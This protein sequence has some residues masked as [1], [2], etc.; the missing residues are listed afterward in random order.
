MA[1][2]FVPRVPYQ[3]N[4][5]DRKDQRIRK[6]NKRRKDT[7]AADDAFKEVFKDAVPAIDNVNEMTDSNKR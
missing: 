6:K 5:E 4:L 3:R 2:H 7:T 1:T